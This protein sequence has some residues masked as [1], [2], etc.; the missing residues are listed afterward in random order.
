[1]HDERIRQDNCSR[2]SLQLSVS[3][4]WVLSYLITSCCMLSGRSLCYLDTYCVI[5]PSIVLSCHPLCYLTIHCVIWSSIVLSGH[6]LCYLAIHC[7]I[8][9]SIVSSGLAV[10][11][12]A[13]L[14]A[15]Q[16]TVVRLAVQFSMLIGRVS[17]YRFR[18]PSNVRLNI[19]L[20]SLM[21]LA[22]GRTR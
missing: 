18:S 21:S 15:I 11:H 2:K 9:P 16:Y 3:A 1:M 4:S 5:W 20:S 13:M 6:P 8:W 22:K 10:C 17:V 14:C 19:R 12:L 7:V